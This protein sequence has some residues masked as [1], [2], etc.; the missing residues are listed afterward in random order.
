MI[1]EY[2]SIIYLEILLCDACLGPSVAIVSI[3][4]ILLIL[5]PLLLLCCTH[6]WR[7]LSVGVILLSLLQSIAGNVIGLDLGS[8]SMKI[9][10]VQPGS[11]LEIVTNLQ[12]KRK[13][14]TCITFY[15]GERMFG[16]DSY[17]LMPRKPELTFQKASRFLG[18]T[19]SHPQ[20]QEIAR[21]YFPY[22]F[23]MNETRGGLCVKLEDTFYTAEELVAMFMQYAKETTANFGGKVFPIT[24][25]L[26]IVLLFSLIFY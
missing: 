5:P 15:R 25:L 7:S 21:Q 23:Y 2:S 20:V 4:Y 1:I 10:I 18:R 24:F 19:L 3:E 11:P 9:G 17:A 26:V 16:A 6:M 14:P 13:T 22:E 12:S 8:D